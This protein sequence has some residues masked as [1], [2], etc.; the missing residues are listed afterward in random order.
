M[1]L[2]YSLI[3][4]LKYHVFNLLHCIIKCM[5]A[6]ADK[7]IL[8]GITGSIAAYKSAELIRRLRDAGAQVRVVMTESATRFITPLTLQTLSGNPVHQHLLDVDTEAQM[9]HIRLARWADFVL[10]A[11]ASA[12][13]VAKLA[14]GFSDD[15]LSTLCL[16]TQAPIVVAPAMNRV[17]WENRSTQDNINRLEELGILRFGP[18]EGEQACGETGPGRM[19]EP[20]QLI[21][22]LDE[23]FQHG[24]LNGIKV[25]VTAGP[26]QEDIDPVR[27]ISNRS[28]GKM[29]FAVAK[30]ARN[31]G[32]QVTLVTG[33]V[34][35]ATPVGIHR[36]DVRTAEEMNLSVSDL[37]KEMDIFISAAAIADY[38]PESSA[39]EK[40]KKTES[41]M[42]LKLVRNPDVLAGVASLPNKP[43]TV[44]FAA[45]TTELRKH[46]LEKLKRKSLDMIA[47]NLVGG[48]SGGFESD[49]N[50]LT[51]FWD[52][53]QVELALEKKEL[54]AQKLIALI[55]EHYKAKISTSSSN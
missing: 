2:F 21:N 27:Y 51:V 25:L 47:A 22:K 8:L 37:A 11:P 28:S 49:A 18:E 36:I 38:R 55:A 44:G 35:L 13:I 32:A 14:H 12:N 34:S 19:L 20:R 23:F 45:E 54:L 5:Y 1:P 9:S 4:K 3:S 42:Q 41:Q 10:I 15:L 17:M 40:I 29:G 50:A 39:T 6:L 46:A 33:P 26:T 16:A 7:N 48:G 43:F 30:A 24:I 31:A 53:G 52:R